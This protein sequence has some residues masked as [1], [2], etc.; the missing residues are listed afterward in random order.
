MENATTEDVKKRVNHETT[1]FPRESTEPIDLQDLPVRRS[2]LSILV[3]ALKAFFW[4]FF[5]WM[6]AGGSQ[7]PASPPTP[8]TSPGNKEKSAEEPAPPAFVEHTDFGAL[9][10]Y[11]P[12]PVRNVFDLIYT[13]EQATS[14]NWI[15]GRELKVLLAKHFA[16]QGKKPDMKEGEESEPERGK[17]PEDQQ[18][19]SSTCVATA[20]V[21]SRRRRRAEKKRQR[22]GPRKTKGPK[23][24]AGELV[25]H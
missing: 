3:E 18:D 17:V 22:R 2:K 12:G 14:C 4:M 21:S 20:Q 5:G 24:T 9:P 13:Y 1:P 25:T 15:E 6:K 11:P 8:T 23:Q 10:K 19:R 7:P 16:K